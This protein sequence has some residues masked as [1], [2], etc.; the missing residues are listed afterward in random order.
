MNPNLKTWLV[1]A[2]KNLVLEA[3]KLVSEQILEHYSSAVERYQLEGNSVLEAE[4]K[5][6][7]D[8]GDASLAAKKFEQ[9]Y[10]TYAEMAEFTKPRDRARQMG[11]WLPCLILSTGGLAVYFLNNI[12]RLN[13]QPMT[14]YGLVMGF[15][16]TFNVFLARNGS[17]KH[18]VLIGWII[19]G[20]F[21]PLMSYLMFRILETSAPEFAQFANY[22]ILFNGILLIWTIAQFPKYISSWEKLS[23][24]KGVL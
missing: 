22:W 8:L 21:V 3:K 2:R 18:Y 20:F 24:L 23:M 9:S 13:T 5:A 15:Y 17:L 6:L 14:I 10:L 16:M 4:A 19:G 1:N 7:A 11:Y 12:G